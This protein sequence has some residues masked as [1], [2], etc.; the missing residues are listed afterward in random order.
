MRVLI[1][2][3]PLKGKV[4]DMGTRQAGYA[5][6]GRWAVLEAPASAPPEEPKP[7]MAATVRSRR[8]SRSTAADL[9]RSE[10]E[11]E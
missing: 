11:K 5:I 4:R 6:K 9:A 7:A 2:K 1:T 10:P 8:V 3:G